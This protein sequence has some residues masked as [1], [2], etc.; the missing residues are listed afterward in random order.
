VSIRQLRL[1]R[2]ASA[3]TVATMIAALSH[4]FGGGS[5]PHPLLM[6]AVSVLLTPVAA[7]LV[8]TRVR[9]P[10]LAAAVT[11]TQVVFHALF[12]IVGG[13]TPSGLTPGGHQHGAIVLNV[14]PGAAAPSLL[15]ASPGMLAAHAA[16]TVITV[17]LLRRGELLV[18]TVAR[19]VRAL[20]RTP[21]PAPSHGERAIRV[22]G[23]RTVARAASRL[24]H[25]CAWRRGPPACVPRIALG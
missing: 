4:T 12:E 2:G 24:L 8:G 10:G 20:L 19:W 15:S 21:Q 9:L 1:L 11:A 18:Q 23:S 17:V 22:P 25:D 14:E 7:L 5:L 3:S 6:L 16:A 13:I